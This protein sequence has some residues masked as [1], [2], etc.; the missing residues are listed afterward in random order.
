M[1]TTMKC[2]TLQS[3]LPF[4]FGLFL[5]CSIGP[6]IF[7][8]GFKAIF[9]T[10]SWFSKLVVHHSHV[11]GRLLGRS[12]GLHRRGQPLNVRNLVKLYN[13]VKTAYTPGTMQRYR[14]SLLLPNSELPVVHDPVVSYH[15][16]LR[17]L[18]GPLTSRP[19]FLSSLK[20]H[21]A[22]H[23]P[24]TQGWLPLRP[25]N[26]S[27]IWPWPASQ[28]R[29]TTLLHASPAMHPVRPLSRA[30]PCAPP[31]FLLHVLSLAHYGS[32]HTS[33]HMQPLAN[34]SAA[35]THSNSSAP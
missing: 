20:T 31:V 2:G 21:H 28:R 22:P 12:V 18:E 26:N 23:W 10:C 30:D 19:S 11:L 5:I 14:P 25:P 35:R 3:H 17:W 9:I 15:R 29:P 8:V 13:Y 4:S 24:S 16:Q 6:H 34:H 7:L 33:V 1:A 27:L 32:D